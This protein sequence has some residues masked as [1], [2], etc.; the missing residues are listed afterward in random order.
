[1]KLRDFDY[2]L[3]PELIAQYP[4]KRREDSRLVLLDKKNGEIRETRFANFPR[5][6]QAGDLL[7]IND[8]RVIPARIYGRKKTGGRV[9][10]F[11]VKRIRNRLWLAMLRPSKRLRDGEII[12]VGQDKQLVRI[13]GRIGRGEWLVSLPD[14]GPDLKFIEAYGH[15]PLPPYIKRRDEFKDRERYQTV[16]ARRKGSIAAPTAGLHFTQEAL[17][18]IMRSG[19]T[20]LPLTLHV[21]PGTFRPLADEKVEAN[22]LSPELIMIRKDYRDEIGEASEMGRRI[23]AVGTTT[24]RALESLAAGRL[25]A[26]DEKVLDGVTY[27]TGW[28]DMFIYPGFKFRVVD[29][30][31]TNLHLP[32]SSLLLLVAAF[33]GRD[34]VLKAYRWAVRRKFRFYS[35]GDA[36]FI[37]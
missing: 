27:I 21:G 24:T 17:H 34:E 5:C 2:E 13:E 14:L 30:L 11:L 35:Y 9:E 3:P 23:V 19:V 1:M 26:H 18:R 33:A 28:T 7:V 31:L 36:M 16:F 12:L 10:I 22:K 4:S 15:V 32:R 25:E 20:V 8:T 29:A 6:L 37:R